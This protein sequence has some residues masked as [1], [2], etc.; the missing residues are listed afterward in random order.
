ML[1]TV[2]SSGGLNVGGK[3]IIETVLPPQETYLKIPVD[4]RTALS[5]KLTVEVS[6][7][8]LVLE[9]ETVTVSASYLDRLVLGGAVVIALLGMLVFIVRRTRASEAQERCFGQTGKIH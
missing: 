2:S 3:T 9:R 8:G 1:V 5:G 6:A 7:G 4:M